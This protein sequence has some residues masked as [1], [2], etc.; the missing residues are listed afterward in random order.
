MQTVISSRLHLHE[1]VTT[2]IRQKSNF[3][4]VGRSVDD[5][6][7]HKPCNCKVVIKAGFDP[8]PRV[9]SPGFR[10]SFLEVRLTPPTWN[11]LRSAGRS[12]PKPPYFRF[13]IHS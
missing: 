10:E 11:W 12:Y 1:H 3:N 13:R 4:A 2:L 9:T 6:F 8:L 5:W 7:A